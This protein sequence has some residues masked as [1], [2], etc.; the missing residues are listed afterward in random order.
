MVLERVDD[1]RPGY[2]ASGDSSNDDRNNGGGRYPESYGD[3]ASDSFFWFRALLF[4]LLIVS[5]CFRAAYLWYAAGGRIHLRR[6]EDGR[7]IGLLYVPPMNNWFGHHHQILEPSP[8]YDRLTEEQVLA[9]PEILYVTPADDPDDI[10]AVR[11]SWI[12]VRND[13]STENGGMDPANALEAFHG[14][15]IVQNLSLANGKSTHEESP[16][17]DAQIRLNS[18]RSNSDDEGEGNES[19]PGQSEKHEIHSSPAGGVKLHTIDI[20]PVDRQLEPPDLGLEDPFSAP[21]VLPSSRGKGP[22][23]EQP[24]DGTRPSLG[25]YT[26]TT[27][28]T[29][30][31]CIDE[32]EEGEKLR[33]LPRCAHAFHTECILP[34]LTERQGSCP[35]CKTSVLEL[36]GDT[37]EEEDERTEQH[38]GTEVADDNGN[39]NMAENSDRRVSRTPDD[40]PH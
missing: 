4:T 39:S 25:P 18:G 11:S 21:I 37:E 8:V 35:L 26:T 15:P 2:G 32:F 29:C 3:G 12:N 5:P 20:V 22:D 10:D 14:S 27:C 17:E 1:D 13:I 36:E 7:I 23:E 24:V 6:N 40:L 28:T 33:L 34:W 16:V 9:L 38:A 30:S 31:I 19:P